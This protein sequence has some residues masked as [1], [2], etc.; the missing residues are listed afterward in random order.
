MCSSKRVSPIIFK[1][2]NNE[3]YTNVQCKFVLERPGHAALI[4]VKIACIDVFFKS[5]LR[6]WRGGNVS[7]PALK[8]QKS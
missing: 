8:A 2:V 3:R 7:G 1:I 5:K 4:K 6:R